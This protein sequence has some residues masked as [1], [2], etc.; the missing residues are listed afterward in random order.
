MKKQIAKLAENVA[1]QMV[2]VINHNEIMWSFFEESGHLVAIKVP[3]IALHFDSE[4]EKEEFLAGL[5][6]L[7]PDAD[8]CEAMPIAVRKPKK[9]KSKQTKKPKRK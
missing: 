9:K 3:S 4:K 2:D 6:H 8:W 5:C 7:Y 1:Q